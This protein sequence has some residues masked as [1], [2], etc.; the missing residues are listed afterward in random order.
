MQ[1]EFPRLGRAAPLRMLAER[2]CLRSVNR[3][4]IH[5]HPPA[6]V[7]PPRHAL[8]WHATVAVWAD[9]QQKIPA[10]AGNLTKFADERLA[11]FPGVVVVAIAPGRVHGHAAFPVQP[12][13]PG[14]GNALFGR[15]EIAAAG[16]E[17][18]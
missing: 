13:H 5:L 8:R 15:D 2:A 7:R 16:V 6:N 9:V 17:L 10:F 11:G 14:G 1:I 18:R 4:A 12:R 3:L